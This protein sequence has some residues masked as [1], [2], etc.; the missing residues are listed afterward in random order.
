V[1]KVWGRDGR[2]GR[3][4][5]AGSVVVGLVRGVA[6]AQNVVP[7]RG[8]VLAW[9]TPWEV[10]G[11]KFMV[12]REA[13]ELVVGRQAC[14]VVLVRREEDGWELVV[15]REFMGAWQVGQFTIGLRCCSVHDM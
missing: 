11:W 9:L 2:G 7:V 15:A 6:L 4:E 3:G 12:H 10:E 8:V 14:D 13:P 1:L 5:G